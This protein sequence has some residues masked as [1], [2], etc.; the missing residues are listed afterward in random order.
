MAVAAWRW[1]QACAGVL[2]CK[3]APLGPAKSFILSA[4]GP[5]SATQQS[6]AYHTRRHSMAMR[7]HYTCLKDRTLKGACLAAV[8]GGCPLKGVKGVRKCKEQCDAAAGCT[9]LVY[10]RR[11]YLLLTTYPSLLRSCTIGTRPTARARVAGVVWA[12][13][14]RVGRRAHPDTV[15]LLATIC[16]SSGTASATC[17]PATTS[18]SRLRRPT[19]RRT[20][21]CYAARRPTPRTPT[22]FTRGAC[23]AG[24]A[25]RRARLRCCVRTSAV[26]CRARIASSC[27]SRRRSRGGRGCRGCK[28]MCAASRA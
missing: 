22:C 6:A 3:A 1:L 24:S 17:T 26:K 23:G 11:H 8:K 28:V 13:V 25:L 4:A 10:N 21:P 19:V 14:V 15:L 7:M 2:H 9:A 18:V 27:S 20:R 5:E 16:P 12:Y